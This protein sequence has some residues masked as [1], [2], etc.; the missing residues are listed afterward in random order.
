M[1]IKTTQGIDSKFEKHIQHSKHY[2]KDENVIRMTNFLHF[3]IRNSRRILSEVGIRF[4]CMPFDQFLTSV[5][6]SD[7][8]NNK[9][10]V[11]EESFVFNFTFV[12]L[13]IL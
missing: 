8:C 12:F 11:D 2:C 5:S 13:Q 9:T 3:I 1:K 6:F 10:H 7:I 4:K